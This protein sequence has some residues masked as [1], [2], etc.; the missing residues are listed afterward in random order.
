MALPPRV[1]IYKV[2][3]VE[4]GSIAMLNG[5]TRYIHLV[6]YFIILALSLQSRLKDL[7]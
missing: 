6:L 2:T 5:I 7:L 4:I 3:K 1:K